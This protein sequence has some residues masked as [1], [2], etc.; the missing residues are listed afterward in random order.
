MHSVGSI[1]NDLINKPYLKVEGERPLSGHL[2]VSGAKNSALVLMAASLLTKET[3][4]LNNIPEL[5]DI[6]VMADLLLSIG[7]NIKRTKNQLQ[8]TTKSLALVNTNLPY[9]LVHALRA[10]F[11]CIGPILARLGEVKIPLPGGCRIG[12]RPIDDHIK[13]LEALGA[14]VT[15]EGVNLIAQTTNPLKKLI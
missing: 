12:S 5:T 3:I 7:A 9:K 13:G 2:K 14:K 8:I 10:S 15:I 1:S 11:V 6:E 4:Q